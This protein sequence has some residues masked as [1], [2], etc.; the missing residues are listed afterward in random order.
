MQSY[1]RQLTLLLSILISFFMPSTM[2]QSVIDPSDPI[3]VH[4]PANPRPVP[5]S[6]SVQK[7]VK[8]NRLNWNTS[9]YKAYIYNGSAFRLKFPKTYTTVADGKKYPIIIMFHGRGESGTVYDNEYQLYHGGELHLNAVDNGAFDGYVLFMQNPGGFWGGD[10]YNRIAA[11]IDYMVA[12]NKVDKYKV[13]IH[14]LSSGGEG[15]W[16]FVKQYPSYVASALPMSWTSIGYKDDNDL[17]Q[18][19]K[20]IPFWNFQGGLDGAP[21]PGTSEQ[22]RDAMLNLGANYK[23]TLYPNDAHGTWND[24]YNESDFF[25]YMLRA[26]K[27]NPWTL[28]GKTEF[29]A[30]EIATINVTLGVSAGFSK[31]EWKKDGQQ[32]AGATTNQINVTTVGSYSCRV[33]RGTDIPANWSEWSPIPTVIKLKAPT[34]APPITV[35]GLKSKV[36]PSLDGSTGVTLEVPAGYTSYLWQKEG[37]TNTLST[38]RTL[39]VTSPGAYKIRVTEQFGC[40]TDF[41]A[42]FQVI[43]ANGPNKP[44]AP[45][46]LLVTTLSKTSLRLDW[47]DNPAPQNDETNF[48]IYQS[49]QPSGPYTLIALKNANVLTHTVTSLNS[50]TRYYYKIRAI[51]N[52]AASTA[53]NEAFGT[54]DEDSQAPGAPIGLNISG[55]T[56][57]SISLSWSSATD[58]V[59]VVAYDIYVNGVNSF[60]TDELQKTVY[61]LTTGQTYTFL[62]KARDL[63]GNVSP[64]SNQVSGQAILSGINYKYFTFT[65][66]WNNLPNFALLT[67]ISSGIMPSISLTPRTQDENF[68]FL[69]EGFI[70][71]PATGTYYFRTN[72]DDGSRLWLGALNGTTSPYT[73][74]GTPLINN[75]GLHG[76]VDVTSAAISLAA[77]IYPIAIAFYEQGGGEQMTVSWRTP[78]SGTTY[79]SI[80]ASAF[81]DAPVNTGTP[82]SNPS[83]LAATAASYGQINLTWLDNSDNETAFEIWRSTNASS[84]FVTVGQAKTNSTSYSDT[85]VSPSTTYYYRIRAIG[86]HGESSLIA[87]IGTG[88][89][90]SWKLDNNYNDGSG[91]NKTLTQNGTPTFD[92]VDKKQGSHAVNLNGSSQYLTIP[93]S[94]SFLQSTYTQKTVILWAK[95][96]NN[97]GNRFLLDIGAS[98]DGLGLRLDANRLYAG[99]ASNNTRRNVSAP[100]T[101]TTWNHIALVYNNNSLKLYVNGIE[102][103][104]NDDLGFNSIGT[105]TGTHRLGYAD[106]LTGNV[107]QTTIPARFSGKLD[108]I[109]IYNRALS[110][111]EI[112]TLMNGGSLPQSVATTPAL[113]A[114]P[115]VPASLLASGVST[116][117]IEISWP[118]VPTE[119]SY[120]L[121][122]ST[123][124]NANYVLFAT[125]G[126]NI[127]NFIDSGL[128][129]NSI[130]Y[131]KVRAKNLGGYSNYSSEDS[132]K[133]G[134]N[135]PK[136]G[137]ITDQ[138]MRYGTQLVLNVSATDADPETLNIS[139]SNL[140]TFATYVPGINGNGTIT[141]DPLIGNQG[142]FNSI[143][144]QVADQ[145]GGIDSVTFQL[146][147]NG[148]FLPVVAD[149]SNITIAERQTAQIALSANDENGETLTW[150]FTGLPAFATPVINGN[151]VTITLAP[152]YSD[153]GPYQV[154]AKVE[155]QSSGVDTA[156]FVINVTDVNPNKKI[157]INF[158]DGTSV[159]PAP[160]NNTNKATPSLNDNFANLKDDGGV[161]TSIGMQI[162]SPWQNLGNATNLLG[163][164][165]GNN[166]G[167]YPDNVMRSAYFT[168]ANTQTIKIYGLG[169]TDKYSFT[170]FGSRGGVTDDR[171]TRYTIGGTTVSLNAA[172][173]TQNTVSVNNLTPQADGSLVLTLQKGT[174]SA[175]GYLNAMI[176]NSSYDDGTVPAKPRN[177]AVASNSGKVNITWIDAAYNET[178]YE[179]YKSTDRN[180]SYALLTPGGNNANLQ[181][182]QD[183]DVVGNVTYYYTIRALNS[184]GSSLYSDTVTITTPNGAPLLNVVADVKIKTQDVV[185]IMVSA[186]DG[187]GETITLT[188]TGL[189]AFATFNDNG[190]GTGVLHVAPGNTSGTFS[191]LNIIATDN[192]GTSSNRQ[193]SIVVTDKDLTSILVNFNQI[194][195]V[196]SPWNSFNRL[197]TA[198]S[199]ITALV[200][201]SG[202]PTTAA[203]TLVDAWENANDLGASTGNNSGIYPDNVLK[204]AYFESSTATKRIRI[205]GLSTVGKKYNLIFFASRGGVTDN[206]NTTFTVGT[207]SV[208]INAA[209]NISNTVQLTGLSADASGT[210][211]FNVRKATGS[212]YA[213]LNAL[214]IQSYVDNG[215]P[216]EPSNLAATPKTTT[217]IQLTWTDKS[218]NESG[219]ELYRSTS[220]NGVYSLITTTSANVTSYLDQGLLQNTVYY[221]KVR[222]VKS[223][224]V[225]SGYSNTA[226]A[227]TL[228]YSVFVN[229]NQE[230]PAGA[231]W[232]NTNKAPIEGDVY[233]NLKNDIN[234]PTGINMT[235]VG[236][237]FYGVNPFGM[238]TGNNSG[239]Y[240]DNV[241]SSTWWLDAGLTAKLRIDG[242]SQAQAYN[243]IF[244]ASRDGGGFSADRTTNYSIGSQSVLLNAV[245]NVNQTVQIN[246]VTADANGS[247]IVEIKAGGASPYAYIGAM[248]IQAYSIGTEPTGLNAAS[249]AHTGRVLSASSP[250]NELS[251]LNPVIGNNTVRAFPNPFADDVIINVSLE[252]P[253]AKL[254]MVLLDLSGKPILSRE[255]SNVPSGNSQHKLNTTGV[256]LGK[257]PP[258]IYLVRIIGLPGGKVETIKLIKR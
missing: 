257:L 241:I 239:I 77:G 144:V 146:L 210:I 112:T 34:V 94:G 73:F 31:Y 17:K 159:S 52:N 154:I 45:I 125:L 152:G 203:I 25:P 245:N 68:A 190:N 20:W 88:N 188:A 249:V 158:T 16:D 40:S 111:T 228:S 186:V 185:D 51:N 156:S 99:V 155:D 113:P 120:E 252:K 91:N 59:G 233:A 141:F 67:P 244:F 197:P 226:N 114:A 202:T 70:K 126:A 255:L 209:G 55:T 230:L 14:G 18:K 74:T 15:V 218:T 166:S 234:N 194:L 236:A 53:S 174:A 122:R 198:N 5:A 177:V 140:P 130:Y 96:A 108:D 36:I 3:V 50:K 178:G 232:N 179:V 93:T 81:G 170:F 63:A 181:A 162:T 26:Y 84:G 250:S 116:S 24:A 30:N 13:N 147:V 148:N 182:L 100:Y 101:S 71:I 142:T 115:P 258:G 256:N 180:G 58:D 143:K 106:L 172:S 157:F 187:P 78:T 2:A 39:N 248:V 207:Q 87:N 214:V 103:V 213:Y 23:Y 89:E 132:A 62:V 189:P 238:N 227:A 199:S 22:V 211:E 107:F 117:K 121:Y 46:G 119:T 64:A 32:I 137:A 231:P 175:Y 102:A 219:F 193:F 69:W 124:T 151:N 208:T 92:A 196:G 204:T 12:N 153:N 44:D 60:S 165:T 76:G 191:G 163:A 54:T 133:T 169:T 247:V 251:S 48:E 128:F 215:I 138:A 221:Y 19:V 131:Y 75:D 95:S 167:I 129:A 192:S 139:V 21:D 229:F 243:F 28:F 97:T 98:D 6:G 66:T 173:N 145:N 205:T 49:I 161:T 83:A 168:D 57:N 56:R 225:Y 220:A 224:D 176:I 10:L 200:D 216:F 127:S 37:S 1:T 79:T 61:N 110:M 109:E 86:Q 90:T 38:S 135:I 217:A 8:T 242:L 201:E 80:P 29:C 164:S 253:V 105:T 118:D 240:P 235:V 72:S 136:L 150:S 42:P 41:S 123:N 160:W 237:A 104:S 149:V 246:N 35:S 9:S 222:A 33:L 254:S 223:P 171:T 4:D 134:N 184:Y 7:W 11:V 47:S 212:V 82:P 65:G 43:D 85:T 27:S 195:P 206:R 183:A